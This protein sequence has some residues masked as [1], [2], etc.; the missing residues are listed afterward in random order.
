MYQSICGA[1]R[2]YYPFG[3]SEASR[4][5]AMDVLPEI[6]S[7]RQINALN[8]N[9]KP[10]Y[11][12]E[13][14][15][16]SSKHHYDFIRDNEVSQLCYSN[17]ERQLKNGQIH[18]EGLVIGTPVIFRKTFKNKGVHNGDTGVIQDKRVLEKDTTLWSDVKRKGC[19]REKIIT[20]TVDGDTEYQIV[21]D[22]SGISNWF[23]EKYFVE[24]EIVRNMTEKKYADICIDFAKTIYCVQGK[25]MK[26]I[27]INNTY[28]LNINL[29]YVALSRA[30]C[31]DDVYLSYKI[32]DHYEPSFDE[33]LT[34]YLSE[35]EIDDSDDED[36]SEYVVPNMMDYI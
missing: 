30:T 18:P 14:G 4:E 36:D 27:I 15:T 25:T 32:D 8:K 31:L 24:P 6:L 13:L 23:N 21:S 11:Q 17:E 2:D 22:A 3:G 28:L 7:Q 29:F 16:N 20:C 10:A 9:H 1:I 12:K 33:N 19:R 26:K 35:S 34:D 5:L